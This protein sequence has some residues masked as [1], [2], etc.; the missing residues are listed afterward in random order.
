MT[1]RRVGTLTFRKTHLTWGG[2]SVVIATITGGWVL[3]DRM[4]AYA[5]QNLV[6]PP[7]KLVVD[8]ACRVSRAESDRKFELILMRLDSLQ[9]SVDKIGTALVQHVGKE[10][11]KRAQIVKV[12]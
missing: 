8:S 9:V 6:I 1:E 2:I 7:A 11:F 5:Q 4:T 10:Q 3:C 12:W